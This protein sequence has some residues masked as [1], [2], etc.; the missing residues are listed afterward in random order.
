MVSWAA[1]LA[2]GFATGPEG[3]TY[4]DEPYPYDGYYNEDGARTHKNT[5]LPADGKW[6]GV[7]GVCDKI[8]WSNNCKYTSSARRRMENGQMSEG[9]YLG[10]CQR[11]FCSTPKK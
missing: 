6:A 9:R 8:D 1:L 10:K 7:P 5:G 11:C 3:G 2:I 4:D